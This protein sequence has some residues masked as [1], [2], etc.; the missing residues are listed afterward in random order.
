MSKYLRHEGKKAVQ[1]W[2]WWPKYLPQPS[3]GI[4]ERGSCHP[5]SRIREKRK[6]KVKDV[7]GGREKTKGTF[8]WATWAKM[9]P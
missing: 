9:K 7:G 8:V 3:E 4:R 2:W 1:I 6:G 5:Y